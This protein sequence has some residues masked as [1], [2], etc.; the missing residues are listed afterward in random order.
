VSSVRRLAV[1]AAVIGLL[2]AST[3]CNTSALT[4]REAVVYFAD[5]APESDHQA[6]LN[7]CGH[8]APDVFPEPIESSSLASNQVGN[9]RFR[10]DHANDHDLALLTE[11]LN[12]QPGV[13]GMDIPDLTN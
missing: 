4:K 13:R 11:C 1:G 2:F 8:V 3:G 9:V 6:V 10:I 7:A 12:K 5:N